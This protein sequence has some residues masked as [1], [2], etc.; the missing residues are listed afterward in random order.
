MVYQ[1]HSENSTEDPRDKISQF[2]QDF[3]NPLTNVKVELFP[4][5]LYVFSHHNSAIDKEIENIPDDPEILSHLSPGA[6]PS[7]VE[8]SHQG[9]YSLQLFRRYE[10][11][12]LSE[13]I[14]NSMEQVL[15]DA[16]IFQSWINR[17]PKGAKQEVHT[18]ANAVLSGIYYHNTTP[19]QGGIVFMNPNPFSKMAMWNTEEGRFF[20]STPRTLVLF[21]SWLEHKTSENRSDKLRVSIAFNAK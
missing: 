15:P 21:P 14:R 3:L 18:H 13:F 17:L 2:T 6:K 1:F 12:A 7:I 9:M 20:P 8:G 19:E 4:T 16:K 5:T 10:L 11:P